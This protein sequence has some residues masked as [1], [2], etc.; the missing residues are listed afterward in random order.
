MNNDAAVKDLAYY[1]ALPYTVVIRKDEDG[2]FVARIQEL[3]GCL[4]DG[5]SEASAI[6]HLHGMRRLWIEDALTRGDAIPE[7]EN[8]TDL[9]SGKWLQR[10]PRKL[11]LD[12]VRLA[13]HE[14]VSLNQLVTSLLSEAVTVRSCVHAVEAFLN[15]EPRLIPEPKHFGMYWAEPHDTTE[16]V[17]SPWIA[18]GTLVQEIAR[19]YDLASRAK[20]SDKSLFWMGDHWADEHRGSQKQLARR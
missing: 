8:Q 18:Q 2:D 1:E 12:L 17:S 16:W 14:N 15:R 7:P 3:P 13:K 20:A 5:D 10:V 9:P 19:V 6:E 11:H 4:A